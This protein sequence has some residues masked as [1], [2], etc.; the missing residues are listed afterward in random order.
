MPNRF[1]HPSDDFPVIYLKDTDAELPGSATLKNNL[2]YSRFKWIATGGTCLIHACKDHYLN[3]TVCFKR[4][5][6]EF[7]NDPI[8]RKRFLREARVTAMIQHPNTIPVYDVGQ[9]RNEGY[10]FTMKLVRGLSLREIFGL[11]R[12][13]DAAATKQWGLSQLVSVA[14]QTGHA[15]SYAHTHG[16]IHRDMKPGNILVGPFGEVLLIDWGL[17]KVWDESDTV[18]TTDGD[19]PEGVIDLELTA[20]G[21]VVATPLY[22]SPEQ[23]GEAPDIDHR[24]DI[25]SFGAILYE[26]LTLSPPTSGRT[27]P[28]LTSRIKS[29]TPRPPSEATDQRVVPPE[30]D[31]LCMACLQRTPGD[32]VQTVA[33]VVDRLQ[34]WIHAD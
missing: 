14:I 3:R 19:D 31:R 22:M 7:A 25:Y 12:D 27:M 34:D 11:L 6:P 26:M 33:D 9:D 16:V 21:K 23:A 15:L 28:E 13:K 10:F 18:P 5:R 2:R 8:Q 4:L 1:P 29:E 17:A 24:T 32:R 20:H 30:L